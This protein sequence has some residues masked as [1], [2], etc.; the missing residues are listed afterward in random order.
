MTID[1]LL[2]QLK[3][4]TSNEE[5]QFIDKYDRIRIT[6]LSEHD[7]W[8]AQNLVRKGIYTISK[9]DTTLIKKLNESYSSR[10]I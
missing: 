9:D 10:S 4:F 6:S 2:K 3:I 8:I 7:H 5:Q 1:Q